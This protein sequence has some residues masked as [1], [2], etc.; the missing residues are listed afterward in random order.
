MKKRKR[1]LKKKAIAIAGLIALTVLLTIIFTLPHLLVRIKLIGDKNMVINY[2]DEYSEPGYKAS[3]MG[4]NIT[5]DVKIDSNVKTDIG[6]YKVVYS[7][8]LSFYNV[9]VKR[10]VKVM[11]ISGPKIELKGGSDYE[12]TVNTDYE[13]PGYTANDNLDGDVTDKVKV[14]GEIDTNKLGNYT[15]TYTVTDKNG[16]ESKATRNVKVEKKKPSQMS[17]TE[18][19]LD[20]WYDEVKLKKTK[21]YGNEYFNKIVM[22]GDSNTM[23][24]YLTGYLKGNNAWAIPCLHAESMYRIDINLYGYNKKMKLID[25]T[26]EYKPGIMILNF[27]T[28][29]TAWINEDTFLEKANLM[30][31]EIKKASPNTKLILISIYPIKSGYNVNQFTQETINKYNFMILEMA[32]KHNLKYL[33]VQEVL[34]GTDGYIKNEY[35]VEDKFHLTNLGHSTVRNYIRTHALEEK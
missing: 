1:K 13:E 31:E 3:K 18:Y 15:L 25:A 7:Y 9:K 24:M 33:D 27:G 23:N 10:T 16:N 5:S 22:A 12:V 6:T 35:V 17:V 4:K 20:G 21:D 28:F 30:I 26:K 32:K 2:G 8:K 34:K 29:S 14:S 11:D 19:T